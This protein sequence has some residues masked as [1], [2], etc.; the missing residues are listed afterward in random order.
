MNTYKITNITNLVGKRD[1]KF[2]SVVNIE[3]V[4]NRT[5]KIIEL[6]S[7][8]NVFITIQSLPL[9][10]HRL[11]IKKL[12]E[13]VEVSPSELKKSIVKPIPK[14][15]R[16]QKIVK[17]VEKE[18]PVVKKKEEVIEKEVVSEKKTNTKKKYSED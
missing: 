6:K 2:N 10:V 12:I 1:P 5:K 16:K 4:D 7:G 13:I 11:R 3:Y 9:S 15:P 8:E 18:Q 17:K 14:A